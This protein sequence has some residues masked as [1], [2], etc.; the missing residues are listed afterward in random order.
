MATT[1]FQIEFNLM[2]IHDDVLPKLHEERKALQD[3]GRE[4]QADQLLVRITEENDKRAKWAVRFAIRVL[5]F[6]V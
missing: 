3:A 5:W 6:R 1:C 4:L 2:A